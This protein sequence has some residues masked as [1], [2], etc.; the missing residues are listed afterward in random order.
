MREKCFVCRCMKIFSFWIRYQIESVWLC[1]CVCASLSMYLVLPSCDDMSV[2][3][4]YVS[5][6]ETVFMGSL[7]LLW[8]NA[9]VQSRS[10]CH[11]HKT[12]TDQLNI[13]MYTDGISTP[14]FVL[15]CKE[16]P[17]NASCFL[18]EIKVYL[19]FPC[20]WKVFKSAAA[21]QVSFAWLW[22]PLASLLEIACLV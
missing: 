6:R 9:V 13:Y 21:I 19:P 15:S 22:S 7:V 14:C 16:T 10:T 1:V 11:F 8:T 4:M 2:D 20:A 5:L 3:H 17:L 18:G 12:S